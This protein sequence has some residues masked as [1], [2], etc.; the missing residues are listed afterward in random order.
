MRLGVADCLL[1]FIVPALGEPADLARHRLLRCELPPAKRRMA[2]LDLLVSSARSVRFVRTRLNHRS[3]EH[4][5]TRLQ[6]EHDR[7]Q[8]RIHAMYVD[9]LD[10]LVD[11]A[12]VDRMSAEWRTEQ[13]RCLQEI[14]RHS[15]ADQ[16]Y[17]TEGVRPLKLAKNARQ[18]FDRQEPR[19]QRRLL[20]FVVSNCSWKDGHLTV[21]YRQP[22]DLLVDTAE[23]A[24]GLAAAEDPEIEKTEIW[25]GRRDS[26][27]N[28]QSQSLL[29]YR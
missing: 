9:K 17:L 20:N 15:V 2:D 24:Q 29:S 1:R 21:R 25:L 18:L 23:N 14:E 12:F 19:E 13:A 27:P 6:A 10:G 8:Q 3:S 5:I 7:L 26:N 4:A 22:F 11:A 28:K 16:S